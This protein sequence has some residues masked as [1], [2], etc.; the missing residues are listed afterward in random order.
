[1][2]TKDL[3]LQIAEERWP[4]GEIPYGEQKKLAQEM[5]CNAGTLRTWL[6]CAGFGRTQ[7]GS[8]RTEMPRI[9]QQ[10]WPDKLIPIGGQKCLA[11]EF[12]Y[13]AS[14]VRVWLHSA[15][16]RA[17]TRAMALR[18]GPTQRDLWAEADMIERAMRR[19]R[20]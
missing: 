2:R 15:G 10:R 7:D 20:Q 16:F 1:M 6:Y 3:V 11:D 9:A 12:G 14:S 17:L 13:S 8:G 5:G 4:D 18:R 19:V